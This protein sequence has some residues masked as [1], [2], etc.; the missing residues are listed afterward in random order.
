MRLAIIDA[1]EGP[2]QR[3]DAPPGSVPTPP[4][5]ARMRGPAALAHAVA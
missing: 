4:A 1:L 5:V 3:D 2:P